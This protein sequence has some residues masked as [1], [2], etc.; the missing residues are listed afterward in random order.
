V[1]FELTSPVRGC[2]I[3]S[4]VQ[5]TTLPTLR[6]GCLHVAY[7]RRAGSAQP[8]VFIIHFARAAVPFKTAAFDR[9][10]TSPRARECSAG[11]RRDYCAGRRKSPP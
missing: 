7:R 2:L 8:A 3:S 11:A 9:S 5:S 4:Q 6:L 10:A 1:R